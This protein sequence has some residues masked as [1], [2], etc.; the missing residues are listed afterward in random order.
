MPSLQERISDLIRTTD[1][2]DE[3]LYSVASAV[4]IHLGAKRAL[5]N[6][7]DLE[8]DLETVHRDY[9]AEG[10]RSVAGAHP[11]SEYSPITSAEMQAG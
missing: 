3:L 6:E 10:V 9:C 2:P 8:R 7:I 1:S 4:A 11:I 5:F